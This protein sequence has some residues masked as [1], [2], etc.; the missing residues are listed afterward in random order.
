MTSDSGKRYD[1]RHSFLSKLG[2]K[3]LQYPIP[4]HGTWLFAFTRR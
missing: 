4:D 1:L 2:F 3:T